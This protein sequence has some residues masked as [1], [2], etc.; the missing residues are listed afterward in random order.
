MHT[1]C[2]NNSCYWCCLRDTSKWC[3]GKEAVCQKRSFHPWVGKTPRGRGSGGPSS[4]PAWTVPRAEEPAGLPPVG[5]PGP[6]VTE[7][8][9]AHVTLCDV[10]VFA[11]SVITALVFVVGSLG[12]CLSRGC[13]SL[14]LPVVFLPS[15]FCRWFAVWLAVPQSTF[16]QPPRTLGSG[17]LWKPTAWDSSPRVLR[18]D[19]QSLKLSLHSM[20]P[21]VK[22]LFSLINK[23]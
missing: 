6:A 8:R 3:S 17:R 5:S 19:S 15:C 23:G 12:F 20:K 16:L 7:R 11:L 22:R 14:W 9:H 13:P 18:C 4:V 21:S 10:S 1:A 2:L